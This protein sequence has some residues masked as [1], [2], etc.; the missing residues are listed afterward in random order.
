[1]DV[2]ALPRPEDVTFQ[3]ECRELVLFA[4]FGFEDLAQEEAERRGVPAGLEPAREEAEEDLGPR[5]YVRLRW[6]GWVCG[7]C[8][9]NDRLEADSIRVPAVRSA[10]WRCARA[11][12]AL[13]VRVVPALWLG[14]ELAR[15]SAGGP[16]TAV[17]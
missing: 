9:A 2:S 15:A 7:R 3:V 6:G 16:E 12:L 10:G 14:E 17:S 13:A 8:P 1:V 4:R 11:A 5:R